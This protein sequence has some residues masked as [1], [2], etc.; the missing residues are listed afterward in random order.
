MNR[1]KEIIKTS[2][3]GI[4][5]NLFLSAFKLV[6]GLL[7]N[8][9]SILIDAVNNLADSLSSALTIIGAKLSEKEPDREHPF[10]YGRIEYLVSMVIGFIIS[11]AGIQAFISSFDRIIHPEEADFSIT[12]IIILVGA[13]I[14]KI[15]I[16]LYTKKQGEKLDSHAL[17]ASGEEALHDALTSV[18]TLIAAV[19]YM[20]KGINIEAYVGLII[21]ALIVKT[22]FETIRETADIILGKSSDLE[23]VRK[24]KQSIGS[25]SEVEGVYDVIIHN[26]GNDKL[27]AS[28]HIEISDKYTAAWIDNLERALTRKVYE[29]TG[30]ILTGISVYA[31]NTDSYETVKARD[32]VRRIVMDT[33][34]TNNMHGFYLDPID[35]SMN[36]DVVFDFGSR[37]KDSLVEEILEKIHKLY[38]DYEV[39]ITIDYNFNADR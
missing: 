34:G 16:G 25:F 10:G 5:A 31:V 35:K 9:V 28:A 23:I 17:K 20:T 24:I 11:Y 3:V 4:I 26:Y 38:P 13:L 6:V 8:S 7:A 36:F 19:I 27:M 39:K 33:P 12:T 18:A 30:V 1:N 21:S 32:D 29:D 15:V 14:V 22:G 37:S 2:Y